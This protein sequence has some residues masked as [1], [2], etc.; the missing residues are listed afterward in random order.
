MKPPRHVGG[1][2]YGSP[3]AMKLLTTPHRHGFQHWEQGVSQSG[4]GFGD[5]RHPILITPEKTEQATIGTWE[6]VFYTE[7]AISWL[8]NP[9]RQMKPFFGV[10]S[11]RP[12]HGP[13]GFESKHTR[14][15]CLV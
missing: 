2:G 5:Y 13:W 6:P 9:A 4:S 3:N 11:W 15:V 7:R 12:P 8:K 14:K 1:D 10:L